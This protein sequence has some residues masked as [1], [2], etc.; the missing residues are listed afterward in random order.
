MQIQQYEWEV[1]PMSGEQSSEPEWVVRGKTIAEL[2][3]ELQTFEDQ[4][5]KVEV[6]IDDGNTRRPISLVKRSSGTCLLVYCGSED[7]P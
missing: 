2:I 1:D 6:S 7:S 3:R 4:T 5:L